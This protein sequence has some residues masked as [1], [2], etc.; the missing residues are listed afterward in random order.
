MVKNA[1]LYLCLIY[2]VYCYGQDTLLLGK[3]SDAVTVLA[4]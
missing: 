4:P 1:Y 3:D 2:S